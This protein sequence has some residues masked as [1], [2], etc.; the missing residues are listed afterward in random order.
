MTDLLRRARSITSPMAHRVSG[1]T[2]LP[3]VARLHVVARVGRERFAFP[4]ADVDEAR[5]EPEV[6][7]APGAQGGFVGQLH[8]RDTNVSAYDAGW[9][10]GI[11]RASRAGGGALVLKRGTTRVAIVVDDVEDLMMVEPQWVRR[12]PGGTDPDA[13]LSGVCRAPRQLGGLICLVRV[14]ALTRAID[15]LALASMTATASP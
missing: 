4:V 13:V 10:L 1:A 7:W 12:V 14:E 3:L 11:A 8:S 15:A 9:A 2:A 6:T 5:D